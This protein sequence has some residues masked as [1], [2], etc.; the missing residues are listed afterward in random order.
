MD[1][2]TTIQSTLSAD[3]TIRSQAETALKQA[4]QHAGF[5]AVL[6]DILQSEQD[7]AVRLSTAVYLK[8]RISRGWATEHTPHQPISEPER[9]PFR[10]RI[11]PVLSSSPPLIRAQ[12][13]PILQTI[14]QYDFPTKWPDLMDITVQLMN[15]QDA[16]QVY[17]GL[18]CLLAV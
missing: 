4:E 17:A 8:N 3:A 16:S 10:D 15:T 6:L 12:L 13:I 11:L 18:Q 7:P 9:K 5:I 14:L 1:L 2:R